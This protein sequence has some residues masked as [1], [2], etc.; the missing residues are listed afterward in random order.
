MS[1][2]HRQTRA[3]L[4]AFF[5]AGMMLCPSAYGQKK[6]AQPLK[7]SANEPIRLGTLVHPEI[8]ESSGLVRSG[9]TPNVFWTHND[10]GNLAR[11]YATTPAGA[12]VAYLDINA[13]NIDWEDIATSTAPLAV[14]TGA[15]SRP[16]GA[17]PLLYISDTGNNSRRRKVVQ[18]IVIEEPL[19]TAP[20][21]VTP[22]APSAPAAAPP[23]SVNPAALMLPAVTPVRTYQLRYPKQPFDCEALVVLGAQAYFFSKDWSG[24]CD[25]YRIDLSGPDDQTFEHLCTLRLPGAVTAADLI[26]RPAEVAAATNT[27]P[28]A[29][30]PAGQLL[31]ALL[32]VGG[33]VLIDLPVQSASNQPPD[34]SNLPNLP[35]RFL[36][37]PRGSAEAITFSADAS[38]VILT[39]EVREIL[40]FP[41]D[42]FSS[43]IKTTPSP[44]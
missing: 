22:N 24:K 8:R 31:L 23:A 13:Y 18:L 17:A 10:S 40:A 6:S 28:Q 38:H 44:K 9:R 34:F 26:Y 11:L 19:L 21:A 3:V 42:S 30:G 35:A 39:T 41:V 5:V 14:P 1:H 12:H 29:A 36:R 25:V 2:T 15:D 16:A 27:V 37:Y 20:S 43:L 7:N 32:T 33:P 4:I